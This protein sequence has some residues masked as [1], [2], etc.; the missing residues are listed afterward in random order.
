MC[1]HVLQQF[2]FLKLAR[3]SS[4][5]AAATNLTEST[6]AFEKQ[7][8]NLGLEDGWIQALKNAGVTTLG[9][10]AF[11]CGQPGTPVTEQDV[12]NLMTA[13][14]PGGRI[15][16]GDLATMRRLIF[17]AQTAVVALARSQADPN[18]DPTL[19]K[20]PP[21]ERSSRIANQ[22][23]RLQGLSMEGNMEVAH[24]VYD[25]LNGMMEADTLK[26][27]APAKC[28]TRMQEITSAKPPKELKLDTSGTGITVKDSITEQQCS[29]GT[30]LDLL[31]AMT[32]RSLAFDAMGLVDFHIFQKW[33]QYLFNLMRQ[34]P[35]PNFKAPTLTQ[36]L[37]ADRQAFVR[38]QELSRDGIKP[39]ADGTRP[40]DALIDNLP[41]DHTVVYY[42]LP[43]A[44]E[45]TRPKPAKPATQKTETASWKNWSNEKSSSWKSAKQ[46]QWKKGSGKT[47]GS[48]KLPYQLKNCASATPE[49]KR[50]CFAYN[51]DGC[52][53]AAAGDSREKGV[54]VCA[55]KGCFGNHPH[56]SCPKK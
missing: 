3:L 20:M 33:I 45:K 14:D 54:H 2:V 7:A 6:A 52:D 12:R 46:T 30:E 55:T 19:R 27:L 49:G 34:P 23:V 10:L 13:S 41:K 37:R 28:I 48:G 8:A 56:Y 15:T 9:R 35:P 5:M 38:L 29:T 11:S 47:G 16:V 21:A 42:M 39:H 22:R 53:K 50:L 44:Q 18:A 43:T 36:L 31:E 1:F 51:I 32:R 17:E 4:I 40:L 26:Y 24:Q 25:Q